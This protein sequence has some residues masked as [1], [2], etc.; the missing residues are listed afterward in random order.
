MLTPPHPRGLLVYPGLHRHFPSVLGNTARAGRDPR[1]GLHPPSASRSPP[2]R[3][4]G[5]GRRYQLSPIRGR[6]LAT[7]GRGT[8]PSGPRAPLWP[9][10][11]IVVSGSGGTSLTGNVRIPA[12]RP[13]PPLS[14]NAG[15]RAGPPGAWGSWAFRAAAPVAKGTDWGD[16]PF[17]RWAQAG[18]A[19]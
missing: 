11:L 18:A 4:L 3:D 17:P 15:G 10:P 1:V 19:P 16:R 12:P 8:V 5:T 2:A 7:V 14:R 6:S 9:P 13:S